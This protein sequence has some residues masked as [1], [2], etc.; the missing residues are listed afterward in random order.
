[1]ENIGKRKEQN[2]FNDKEKQQSRQNQN[3][4]NISN[5]FSKNI[6][7]RKPS[8]AVSK[9]STDHC[10]FNLIKLKLKKW[11]NDK[12][13]LLK[14]H[15]ILNWY[16]PFLIMITIEKIVII[17]ILLN[18]FFLKCKFRTLRISKSIQSKKTEHICSTYR[19][20]VK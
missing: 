20:N 17:F 14:I 8:F 7:P 15:Q 12:K 5:I 16:F 11:K 13:V 1:M 6:K 2:K 9:Y 4:L 3:T 19:W 10:W 18:F